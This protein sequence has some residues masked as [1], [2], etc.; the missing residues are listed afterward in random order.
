MKLL[1]NGGTMASPDSIGHQIKKCP[2]SGMCCLLSRFQLVE[3]HRP[4]NIQLFL[5]LFVTFRNW[6][7]NL[8]P[9]WPAFTV[10]EGVKHAIEGVIK[11]LTSLWTL[12]ILLQYAQS[13]KNTPTTATMAWMMW[14]YSD[15]FWLKFSSI[16]WN[17]SLT[18]LTGLRI[19]VRI[20]HG[21]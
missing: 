4:T 1:Y 7:L 20:V 3:S 19:N 16:I 9:H 13:W 17:S 21:L 11:S 12:W 10:L 8:H 14:E 5:L 15:T 18:M 2:V 6:T